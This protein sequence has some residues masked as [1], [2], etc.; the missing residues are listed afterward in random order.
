MTERAGGDT[1][2]TVADPMPQLLRA[3]DEP[4]PLLSV[5]DLADA[6]HA[7]VSSK[8]WYGPE[9]K[10]P[11]TPRNLAA[12]L[13]IEA[14]ELMEC[15]QWDDVPDPDALQDELADVVLYALQLAN[16]SGLDLGT[17]VARKLE[18]NKSRTWDTVGQ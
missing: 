11:Q 7:F 5:T 8:G 4:G 18:R 16:V 15:F 12:S 13:V 6:M 9:S 10:R 3:V 14:G 1:P 2:A 17:V